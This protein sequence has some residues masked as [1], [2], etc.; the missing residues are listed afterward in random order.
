MCVRNKFYVLV[1]SWP[2]ENIKIY[3]YHYAVVV[4]LLELA[5]PRR[6][7]HR[8]LT[9]VVLIQFVHAK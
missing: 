1:V 7:P 4:F 5:R 2:E 3:Y 8:N 6:D 9:P